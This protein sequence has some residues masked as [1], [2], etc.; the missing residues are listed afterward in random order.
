MIN[1]KD[2]EIKKENLKNMKNRKLLVI[3]QSMR[4]K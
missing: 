1:R 2:K 4:D 3:G